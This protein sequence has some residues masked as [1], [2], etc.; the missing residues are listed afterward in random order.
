[1]TGNKHDDDRLAGWRL[2]TDEWRLTTEGKAA[3]W[4][5]AWLAYMYLLSMTE[6]PAVAIAV[7]IIGLTA[8]YVVVDAFLASQ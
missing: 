2:I 3:A 6:G 5:V 4:F 7:G 1:M 8:G